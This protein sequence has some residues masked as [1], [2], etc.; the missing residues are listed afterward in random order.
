[1]KGSGKRLVE[2]WS[3]ERALTSVRVDGL[4]IDNPYKN[5]TQKNLIYQLLIVHWL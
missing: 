5:Y 3:K 2:E 4:E 1:M